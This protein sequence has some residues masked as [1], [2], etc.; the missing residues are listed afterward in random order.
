MITMT[1]LV[2]TITVVVLTLA[3]NQLGPRLVG[4]FMSDN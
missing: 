3:A 1:S 4:N 2:V